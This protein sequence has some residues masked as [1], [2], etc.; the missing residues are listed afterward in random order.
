MA[1]T[2]QL[3]PTGR[4]FIL[5]QR[6][7][8]NLP[9]NKETPI[10]EVVGVGAAVA[11]WA[12]AADYFFPKKYNYITEAWNIGGVNWLPQKRG[13]FLQGVDWLPQ[14]RGAFLW[15]VDW[16][17]QKRGAFLHGVDWL[18]QKRVAFLHGVDWLPQKRGAF[19]QGVDCLPQK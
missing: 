11:G 17:L 2:A 15:D 7:R 13:A 12:G 8:Q 3:V 19:L 5:Y 4:S 18:P 10:L 14:K 9:V 6:R 16:P 1:V